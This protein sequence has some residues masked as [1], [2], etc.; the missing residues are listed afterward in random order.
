LYFV[1][2]GRRKGGV[3]YIVEGMAT[4]CSVHEATGQS[5]VVAFSSG[6]L[7]AVAAELRKRFPDREI[8]VAG[9]QGNGS[10]KAVEAARMIGGK[11]VLPVMP[12]GTAGS[13]FNDVH[14]A[15]GLDEVARQLQ[16]AAPPVEPIAEQGT[17]AETAPQA[18][19]ES[20]ISDGWQ[21]PLLFEEIRTPEIPTSILSGWLRSFVEAL[22]ATTQT[23]PAMA[24]MMA[25]ATVAA[26]VQ[27]R[28]QV[29][30]TPDHI[31]PLSL[32]TVTG[33]PPASRKPRLK[34]HSP[35]Q[36]QHGSGS[37]KSQA[38]RNG[39]GLLQ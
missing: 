35:R 24:V 34:M 32:W 3:A 9:D 7:P 20:V 27:K 4:G 12:D 21:E 28:F 26:C 18:A 13:D 19:T 10:G 15:A 17:V 11:V 33:M 1:I 37:R 5:V 36:L 38:G 39:R 25:L 14:A 30:R 16:Q 23:P 22:A 6:K 29:A 31:E 2:P 8:I